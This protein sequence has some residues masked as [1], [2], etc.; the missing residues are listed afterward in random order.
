MRWIVLTRGTIHSN[1]DSIKHCNRWHSKILSLRD[2][3]MP[4]T[5]NKTLPVNYANYYQFNK[6]ME[7]DG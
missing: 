4:F 3:P 1:D 6:K 7:V 2:F 5:G